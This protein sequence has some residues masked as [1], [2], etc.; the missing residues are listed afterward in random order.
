M[1]ELLGYNFL[2]DGDALNPSPTNIGNVGKVILRNSDYREIY[3][4]AEINENIDTT[5]PTDWDIY[6]LMLDN[7]S[8]LSK[9]YEQDG[10]L[11][12]NAGSID[13]DINQISAIRIKRRK[14]N[15]FNWV[16]IYEKQIN[17]ADDLY[18]S[19]VDYFA[20]N[21]EEY[22]YAWTIVFQGQEGQYITNSVESKFN[23][24]FICDADTI[25][26]FYAGVSYGPSQQTQLVGIYNPIGQKYPIYVTN[27]ATNYQTGVL[28]G[29]IVGNYE[30]TGVFNRKEMVQ[31]KN[32]LIAWLT[33]KQAKILKD[34]NGNMWLC[35]VTGAPSVSYDSQWGN[36]MMEISFQYGEVGDPNNVEDMQNVGLWPIPRN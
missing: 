31:Q 16:T 23:G 9:N 28:T 15:E 17:N 1:L 34:W 6:T 33:N 2:L 20:A 18:F 35:F 27:G 25:Y 24:V 3:A 7:F 13:T 4:T 10:V 30:D 26:K 29:K 5:L 22:E 14:L 32:E 12:L 19:G 21:E 36:G 8:D 11:R